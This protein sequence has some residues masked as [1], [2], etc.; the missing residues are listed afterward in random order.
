MA[1]RTSGSTRSG[2]MGR[3]GWRVSAGVRPPGI[4]SGPRTR[5]APACRTRARAPRPRR[6]RAAG[7]RP[8]RCARPPT[9]PASTTT[10]TR[11]A[12]ERRRERGRECDGHRGVRGYVAEAAHCLAEMNAVQQDGGTTAPDDLLDRSWPTSTRL[13]SRPGSASVSRRSRVIRKVAATTAN[14]PARLPSCI[15]TRRNAQSASG[16]SLTRRND[17]RLP[18]GHVTRRTRESSSRP[19]A[20]RLRRR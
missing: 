12:G 3:S 8:R 7:A 13:D 5:G 17:G 10:T 14:E 20:R 15:G 1:T 6:R 4:G 16:R 19:P 2:R 9:S 11:R 18:R